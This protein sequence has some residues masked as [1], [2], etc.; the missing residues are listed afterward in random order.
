MKRLEWGKNID[1]EIRFWNDWLLSRGLEWKDD[2]NYRMNPLSEVNIEN[3]FLV[4]HDLEKFYA[5]CE[6][7]LLMQ[8]VQ[9]RIE[10]VNREFRI[11]PH[12][13]FKQ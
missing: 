1:S 8:A 5:T 12:P 6:D 9:H 7:G 4:E 3:L 10:V 13:I 11:K 2:Y